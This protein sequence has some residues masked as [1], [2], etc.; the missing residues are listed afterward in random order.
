M[1]VTTDS[2]ITGQAT[3]EAATSQVAT[4]YETLFGQQ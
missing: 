3:P 2:V 1:V 4:Q